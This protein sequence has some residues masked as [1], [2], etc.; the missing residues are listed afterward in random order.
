VKRLTT[1]LVVLVAAIVAAVFAPIASAD[2]PTIVHKTTSQTGVLTNA[3]TFPITVDSTM[4]ETDRFF[5]DQSGALT[6]ANANVTEQDTFSANG[7]SLTGLPYSYSIQAY[8]DSSGN[9]TA[10]YADGVVER[11]PLPD[12]T[13]FQSAGR[14]NFAAQGFPT[15]SITPNA[16]SEGN[17]A[18]FCAALAP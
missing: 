11:V 14:V 3:C 9:I 6:M 2:Q 7:K 16:G 17:L 5:F 1:T 18:G 13:V 10:V 12:G 8:F 4:T 15:F